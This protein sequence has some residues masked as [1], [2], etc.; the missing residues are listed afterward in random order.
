LGHRTGHCDRVRRSRAID[1][2]VDARPGG[3]A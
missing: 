2:R 1:C 3:T